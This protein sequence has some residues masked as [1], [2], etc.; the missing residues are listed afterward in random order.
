M[1]NNV[2]DPQYARYILLRDELEAYLKEKYG[3]DMDFNVFVR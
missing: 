1:A 2:L 3:A